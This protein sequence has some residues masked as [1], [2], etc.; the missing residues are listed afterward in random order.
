MKKLIVFI[1]MVL[2]VLTSCSVDSPY[3]TPEH[4]IWRYYE[5]YKYGFETR[6]YNTNKN[7]FDLEIPNTEEVYQDASSIFIDE[8]NNTEKYDSIC[9]AVGDG[10]YK[11]R[12]Y[13]GASMGNILHRPIRRIDVTV[14]EDFDEQHL[15]GS[16]VNDML[17]I[18]GVFSV[19]KQINDKKSDFFYDSKKK[20]TLDEFN[21]EIQHLIPA[22]LSFQITKSPTLSY[23][24]FKFTV[25]ISFDDG[26]SVSCTTCDVPMYR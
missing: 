24:P 15:N 18:T 5:P 8:K 11:K 17:N 12:M 3:Y 22:H 16:N 9:T 10:G 7:I 2:C 19:E 23:G 4:V 25:T 14:N 21:S 13:K 6:A 1:A 26:S 20:I